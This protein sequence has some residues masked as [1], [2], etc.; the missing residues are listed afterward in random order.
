MAT[1]E[2]FE[3]DLQAL[4]FRLVQ[5][6]AST[7][8]RQY[9]REESQWLTFWVHWD[10]RDGS[11]LFTWELALGEFMSDRG[12]QVGSNEELNSFLYPKYDA[13]GEADIAFV[14]QELDRAEAVLRSVDFLEG[15]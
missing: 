12:L 9:A 8:V 4:N 10:P 13:R 1:P 6:R 5:Q 14:V 3:A 7:G 15:A 11:V 2:E